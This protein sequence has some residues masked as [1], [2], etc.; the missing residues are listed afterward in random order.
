M[1][2]TSIMPRTKLSNVMWCSQAALALCTCL[3]M[4]AMDSLSGKLNSR[5]VSFQPECEHRMVRVPISISK[6]M[7]QTHLCIVWDL[8]HLLHN[9]PVA[10]PSLTIPIYTPRWR[11]VIMVKC[12]TQGHNTLTVTG[13]KP[14]TLC[15]W[16]QHRSVRPHT[17]TWH[18]NPITKGKL[19]NTLV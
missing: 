17:H 9:E 2:P 10:F 5:K 18:M 6:R 19:W 11:G 16:T 15:L 4:E 12:L 8:L 1:R 3:C 14:T 13:F 7:S